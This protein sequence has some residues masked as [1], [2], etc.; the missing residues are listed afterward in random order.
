MPKRK[1]QR[2][3]FE[4]GSLDMAPAREV[5]RDTTN[6][7]IGVGTLELGFAGLN[8]ITGLVKK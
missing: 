3:P 5:V 1:R 8:A 4:M 7:M 2:N 6:L